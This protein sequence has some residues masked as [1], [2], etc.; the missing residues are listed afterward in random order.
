MIDI[1]LVLI[2]K[3]TIFTNMAY[4]KEFFKIQLQFARIISKKRAIP[5]HKALYL[6]TC[7]YVRLLGYSDENRPSETNKSWIQ[8]MNNLPK[9]QSEQVNYLYERYKEYELLPKPKSNM[10]R[11][12]CFSYSYHTEINQFEL[13][14]GNHD[15]KGNLGADRI[16]ARMEDWKNLFQ[17]IYDEGKK[18]TTCKIATWLLGINAFSRLLPPDFVKEAKPINEDTAQNFTYWGPLLNRF[19]K[20]K[21]AMKKELLHKIRTENHIYIEDYFPRRALTSEVKTDIFF[22]FYLHKK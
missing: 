19:G 10:K 12:G 17:S 1:T 5:Y 8:I 4:S 22:D 6:Y 13:H 20:I 2:L 11:F 14:F 7:L 21:T 9:K 15:P 18:D 16:Q 3:S